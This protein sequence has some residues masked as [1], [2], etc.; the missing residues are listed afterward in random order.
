MKLMKLYQSSDVS[1]IPEH[2]A[3]FITNFEKLAPLIK[4]M[5][6]NCCDLH[7]FSPTALYITKKMREMRLL[8]FIS[9]WRRI[10][11]FVSLHLSLPF[12]FHLYITSI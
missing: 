3:I 2:K 8:K 11:N 9:F 12:A 6:K 4:F 10:S 7:S 5:L 1:K